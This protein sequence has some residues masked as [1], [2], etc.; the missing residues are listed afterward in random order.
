MV[1]VEGDEEVRK[2]HASKLG[3]YTIQQNRWSRGRP[4]YQLDSELEL[5]F[6]LMKRVSNV[7]L[8]DSSTTRLGGWIQSGRGTNSPTD[9]EA[10]GSVSY[11]VTRWRYWD[12]NA[13]KEGHFTVKCL[14]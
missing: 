1:E 7:W 12:G 14:D 2:H 9:P 6:L 11:G 5:W 8:I 4:V 10:A 13:W 3:N